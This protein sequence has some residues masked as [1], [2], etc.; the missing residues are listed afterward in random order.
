[1]TRNRVRATCKSK[2][3]VVLEKLRLSVPAQSLP[4]FF[5][6]RS[7]QALWFYLFGQPNL[8]ARVR[9]SKHRNDEV[10][11][12]SEQIARFW[13]AR[14]CLFQTPGGKKRWRKFSG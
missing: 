2:R 5:W 9:V 12:A 11:F 13:P 7:T 1:M 6:P 4:V 10:Q 14:R 3:F 8:R